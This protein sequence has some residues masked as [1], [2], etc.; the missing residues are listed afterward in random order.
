MADS[1]SARRLI[2]VR[3]TRVKISP[4]RTPDSSAAD[5]SSTFV[6][7]TPPRRPDG[8]SSVSCSSR[9]TIPRAW[10]VPGSLAL[11]TTRGTSLASKAPI[12][13]LTERSLPSLMTLTGTFDPGAISPITCGRS[14]ETSICSP[15]T[16]TMISPDSMPASSA[17]ESLPTCATRAPR[18]R[19][20]SNDSAKVRSTF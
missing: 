19:S 15:S 8:F 4:A 7:S 2:G 13:I 3:P 12:S 20:K 9:T 5:S 6:T 11:A 14:A 1:T 10:S 18:G 17:G 16:S